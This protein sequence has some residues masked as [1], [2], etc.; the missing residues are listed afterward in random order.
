MV[1]VVGNNCVGFVPQGLL[2]FGDPTAA[3]AHEIEHV[4]LRRRAPG[5]AP[6]SP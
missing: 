4:E 3:V 1:F 6:S 2:E 5:R